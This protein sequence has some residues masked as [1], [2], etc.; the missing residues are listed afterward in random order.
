MIEAIWF[1][2]PGSPLPSLLQA[3]MGAAA[4]GLEAVGVGLLTDNVT[5]AAVG[6]AQQGHRG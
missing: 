4:V 1:P 5:G 2:Q 3:I 6:G